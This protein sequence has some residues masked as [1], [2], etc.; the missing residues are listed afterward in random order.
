VVSF[1][2]KLS[3]SIRRKITQTPNSPAPIV[4]GPRT[5][6]GKRRSRRNALKLGI[7]SKQLI[8]E[9]ERRADFEKLH[10]GLRE[11]WQPQGMMEDVNVYDLAVLYLR[12]HRI[13]PAENAMIARS[14]LFVGVDRPNS[15]LP[16]PYLLRGALKDGSDALSAKMVLLEAAAEQLIKLS[17]NIVARGFDFAENIRAIAA[18]YGS[19]DPHSPSD[20]CG[21]F[22]E[23]MIQGKKCEKDHDA[24]SEQELRKLATQLITNEIRRLSKLSAKNE[25][26]ETIWDSHSSL[27]PAQADLDKIIR[28]ESHLSREIERKINLLQQLQRARRGYP[29]S[30]TIKV[31][32]G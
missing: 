24:S 27:L 25:L 4:T 22:F 26:D 19:F 1:F 11:Y 3:V 7:F 6:A 32:V 12:A 2:P 21:D 29:P 14:P 9:G 31:D 16:R 17:K 20:F 13:I 28:Y 15:N 23:L 18:I 8:L 30:P 5:I 10:R